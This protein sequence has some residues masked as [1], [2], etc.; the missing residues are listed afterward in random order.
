[1]FS[2]KEISKSKPSTL[3][4]NTARGSIINFE[5]VTRAVNS[6]Q[7]GGYASDVFPVEPLNST[8]F[9]VERGFYFTPHI[10]GNA[11][12]AIL[13]MGRAAIRGLMEYQG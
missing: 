1:M 13:N 4:I 7:L 12:E 10:G 11:D 6:H 9:T 2:Q 5:D 8:E 3:V